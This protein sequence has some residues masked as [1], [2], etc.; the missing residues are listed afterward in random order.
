MSEEE[1]RTTNQATVTSRLLAIVT[2]FGLT[3]S[4][5]VAAG[6]GV[7]IASFGGV[8]AVGDPNGLFLFV[9]AVTTAAELGF[10]VVGYGYVRLRDRSVSVR[11][12]SGNDTRITLLGTVGA[13]IVGVGLFSLLGVIGLQPQTFYTAKNIDTATFVAT[14]AVIVLVAPPAEEYLFR[15]AIQ[16]RLHDSFGRTGAIAGASLLFGAIHIPNYLGSEVPAVIA[17]A[18]ILTLVGAVFGYVYERT[19]NLLV[20]IAVHTGYNLALMIVSATAFV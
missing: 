11:R 2:A 17:G 1:N 3:V 7:L 5:V 10:L 4:G 12:P 18:L 20:P 14:A 9:V 16:G 8:L 15:G 19:E 6:I 13:F